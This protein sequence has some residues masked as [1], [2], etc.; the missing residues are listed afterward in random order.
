MMNYNAE[1][2]IPYEV[3]RLYCSCRYELCFRLFLILQRSRSLQTSH[4][5][6]CS[7]FRWWKR[8]I[9]FFFATSLR[10]RYKKNSAA[11]P[12]L[13]PECSYNPFFFIVFL[14]CSIFPLLARKVGGD[15]TKHWK[16]EII[17]VNLHLHIES[18]RRSNISEHLR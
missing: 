15:K 7:C 5:A 3:E 16:D 12:S 4:L 2:K 17:S 14:S 10:T 18:I 9:V 11:E 1:K 13:H 6:R 8:F